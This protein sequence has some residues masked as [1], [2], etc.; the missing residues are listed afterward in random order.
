MPPSGYSDTHVQHI[1]AFLSSCADAV[2]EAA[3]AESRSVATV[4]E[5]ERRTLR[6]AIEDCAF[7][8]VQRMVLNL[9]KVFYD[10]LAKKPIANDAAFRSATEGAVADV[11]REIS[12][13]HIE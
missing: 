9:T 12:S 13:I 10:E 2:R 7:S 8:P 11:R 6:A 5:A 4:L 1:T 3:A